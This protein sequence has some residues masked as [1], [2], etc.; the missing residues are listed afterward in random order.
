MKHT[1]EDRTKSLEEQLNA[2]MMYAEVLEKGAEGWDDFELVMGSGFR[3]SLGKDKRALSEEELKQVQN[4]DKKVKE[5]RE[6]TKSD[7]LKKYLMPTLMLLGDT[8]FNFSPSNNHLTFPLFKPYVRFG[9]LFFIS[10]KFPI[11]ELFKHDS[12]TVTAHKLQV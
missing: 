12:D 5:I 7:R 6:K 3:M 1:L 4:L 10:Q 11:L 2:Y 8:L 9:A